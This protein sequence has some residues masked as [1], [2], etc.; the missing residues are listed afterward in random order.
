MWFH[1]SGNKPLVVDGDA[2]AKSEAGEHDVGG[3]TESQA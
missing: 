3:T 1:V 2:G